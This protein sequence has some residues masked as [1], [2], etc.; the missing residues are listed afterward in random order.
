M[1]DILYTYIHYFYR[2]PINQRSNLLISLSHEYIKYKHHYFP[3][4]K[5]PCHTVNNMLPLQTTSDSCSLIKNI[6]Y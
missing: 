2:F 6:S 3:R 5:T 1:Y 4:N